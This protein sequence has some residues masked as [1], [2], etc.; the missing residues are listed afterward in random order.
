MWRTVTTLWVD[1][2]LLVVA[3]MKDM[4]EDAKE[5]GFRVVVD[6]GSRTGKDPCL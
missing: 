2:V 5:D 3:A 1:G 6:R 4:A